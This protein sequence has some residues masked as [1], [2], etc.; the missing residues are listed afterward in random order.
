MDDHFLLRVDMLLSKSVQ[1]N[2]GRGA[3]LG[4]HEV[5]H[6]RCGRH[7]GTPDCAGR[8][9]QMPGQNLKRRAASG[10][11]LPPLYSLNLYDNCSM[12]P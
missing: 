6:T 9:S 12:G 10:L 8:A 4:C 2:L 7:S 11:S 3:N 1:V 5:P